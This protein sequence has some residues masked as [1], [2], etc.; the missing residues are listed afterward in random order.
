M[1]DETTQLPHDPVLDPLLD[2]ALAPQDA[3][4]DL[5]NRIVSATAPHLAAH[6]RSWINRSPIVARLGGVH[7][8]RYAA[9]AVILLAEA[10]IWGTILGIASDA[11]SMSNIETK[12]NRLDTLSASAGPIDN[13]L[14]LL[15]LRIDAAVDNTDTINV[16]TDLGQ[17]LDQWDRSNLGTDEYLIF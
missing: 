11:K 16:S 4:L 15:S 12:L 5:V 10:G 1:T 6:R 2:E 8:L 9:A 7:R 14:E 13:E 3:P 17:V